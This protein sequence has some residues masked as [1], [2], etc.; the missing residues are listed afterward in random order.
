M[1]WTDYPSAIEAA[2]K[3][4]LDSGGVGACCACKV[5]HT[6]GY[7]FEFAA[8]AEPELL[9]GEVW[10]DVMFEHVQ[11]IGDDASKPST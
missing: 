4:G 2:R 10:R 6:G 8:Q 11:R 3:L 5:N 1:E 9:D 7:E